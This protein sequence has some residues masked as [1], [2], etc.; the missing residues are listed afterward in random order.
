[1]DVISY[2]L[3]YLG[4]INF[5]GLIIM[6]IDKLKAKKRAWRV[7]ESTLFVI[8][9]IGGSLGTTIGMFLFRHKTKHWYFRYGMPAIL[10][11]QIAI[12]VILMNSPIHFSIL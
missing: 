12:V 10:I 3:S 9:F 5:I 8:A 1:M 7:P 6:G 4:V 11:V 2:I